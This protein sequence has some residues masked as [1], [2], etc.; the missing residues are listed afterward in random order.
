MREE[1]PIRQESSQR[2]RIGKIKAGDDSNLA[3]IISE[4]NE[5]DLVEYISKGRFSLHNIIEHLLKLTGP[6]EVTLVTWA[7]TEKPL[8]TLHRLKSEGM[9]T[10]LYCLLEHKV[11]GHNPK[12]FHFAK[13]FF[14]G[15]WLARCH[16]KSV[17][18]EN[19]KYGIVVSTSANLTR[20]LRIENGNIKVSQESVKFAKKWILE[21]M[22]D[23]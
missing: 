13:T 16:A 1:Q 15:I 21:H 4:L 5:G 22:V 10:E 2:S 20:N 9:I 17:V 3:D 8:R 23:S 18:I 14:N 12:S 19:E 6:A 11:P 7:M